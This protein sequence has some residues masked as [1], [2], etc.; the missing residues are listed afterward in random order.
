MNRPMFSESEL[1]PISALQHLAFCE[2]QWALIHLENAWD[3]NL[4]TTEGRILHK[5]ADTP[6]VES[7]PGLRIARGLRL[8]NLRLGLVGRA[9]V[10]EFHRVT[11]SDGPRR[12]PPEP[13]VES[14][15]QLDGVEGLWRPFPVEYKRGRPK[16]ESW[17]K[18]QLCAQALCLEEMLG[19]SLNSGALFYGKTRRRLEVHFDVMLRQQTEALTERLQML[20][21]LRETP[22]PEYR[23]RCDNCSLYSI[24]MPKAT[25]SG[26][27]V[28][29][30]LAGAIRTALETPQGQ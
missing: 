18:V 29:A 1:L 11:R 6:G 3:E 4:L 20:N 15:I 22:R 30:Y 25:T 5:R 7:R 16:R 23:K 12:G 21:R 10:V 24:C 17:D 19:I 26:I 28:Q 9:D 13:E 8:R 14:G 27:S 2:R